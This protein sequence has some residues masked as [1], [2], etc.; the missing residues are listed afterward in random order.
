[1][2]KYQKHISNRSLPLTFAIANG[3]DYADSD[4]QLKIAGHNLYN[5]LVK[6]NCEFSKSRVWFTYVDG[7]AREEWIL[8][9]VIDLKIPNSS[10]NYIH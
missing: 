1:M 8:Q 2:T 6:N 10:T 3:I 9:T 4:V 5:V 7:H